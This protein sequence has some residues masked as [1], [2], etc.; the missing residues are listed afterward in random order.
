MFKEKEDKV[1][2]KIN[3]A[4]SKT[5]ECGEEVTEFSYCHKSLPT[6]WLSQS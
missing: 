1:L 6:I 2:K 5:F 4:L 3:K